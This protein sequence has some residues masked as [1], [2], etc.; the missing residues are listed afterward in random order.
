M[1]DNTNQM[2]QQ[3]MEVDDMNTGN[4]NAAQSMIP[5]HETGSMP[6]TSHGMGYS[7]L[8][9]NSMQSNA[10]HNVSD[11][12]AVLDKQQLDQNPQQQVNFTFDKCKLIVLNQKYHIYFTK[13]SVYL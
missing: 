3:S 9:G 12:N 2:Q 1:M 7:S 11:G 6:S 10:T 4:R 5:M 13:I 8:M